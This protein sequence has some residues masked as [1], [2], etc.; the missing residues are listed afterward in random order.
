MSVKTPNPEQQA[1][2]EAPGLVFVSAG[3]GTGKTLVLVERFV[4]A[5]CDQGL[6]VDSVLVITY[7][8]RA[9]GELRSRIRNRLVELGRTDLARELDGAWISTIALADEIVVLDA[10]RIV[11]RG[12][13]DEL[14]ET[15]AV[16]HQ[17]YEHGLLEHKMIE[18]VE[19]TA[20]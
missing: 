2:I 16:Y 6:S 8:D 7:T 10:G 17:I 12:T 14:V 20:S 5:V 9:A 15:D 18:E 11:A 4:R 1:A 3:A 19:A 13:H